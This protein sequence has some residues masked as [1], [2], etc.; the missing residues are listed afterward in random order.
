MQKFT[1]KFNDVLYNE[2]P[3]VLNKETFSSLVREFIGIP[4][5]FGPLIIKRATDMCS[6]NVDDVPTSSVSSTKSA[7]MT[8]MKDFEDLEELE[9]ILLTK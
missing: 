8:E 1:Q 9:L 6:S 5:Y 3:G 4:S 2:T 7:N